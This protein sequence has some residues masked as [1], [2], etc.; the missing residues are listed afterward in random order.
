MNH[1]AGSCYSGQKGYDFAEGNSPPS[2]KVEKTWDDIT[3]IFSAIRTFFSIC[4]DLAEKISVNSL[5]TRYKYLFRGVQE[6]ITEKISAKSARNN[7]LAEIAEKISVRSKRGGTAVRR[8]SF[9]NVKKGQTV[10]FHQ[11]F[12][13]RK[14]ILLSRGALCHKRLR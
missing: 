1:I 5:K 9:G 4:R 6:E 10:F 3:E 12:P 11:I 14:D 2:L 8:D 13:N 7:E